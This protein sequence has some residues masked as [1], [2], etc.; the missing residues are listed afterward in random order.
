MLGMPLQYEPG[1]KYCYSNL[2]F[3]ILGRIIEKITD[4]TYAQYVQQYIFE[5]MGIHGIEQGSSRIPF[6]DE[7]TYFGKKKVKSIFEEDHGKE[8]ISCYGGF[9][10]EVHDAGGAWVSNVIDLMRFMMGIPLLLDPKTI[11]DMLERLPQEPDDL[12][13]FWYG[14][15]WCVR[16]STPSGKKDRNWWHNGGLDGTSTILVKTERKDLCWALLLNSRDEKHDYDSMI[17]KGLQTIKSWPVD[18][19]FPTVE[20]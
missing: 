11:E 6:S 16:Y 9:C 17:W 5:P 1:E 7:V 18:D 14:R 8:V 19:L 12:S 15:G 20:Q 2:G 13:Q 10:L 3:C 4:M